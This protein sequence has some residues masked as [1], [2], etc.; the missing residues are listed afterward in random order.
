M[1]KRSVA[2]EERLVRAGEAAARRAGLSFSAW[3]SRA[4]EHALLVERGLRAVRDW[5]R[6]HGRLTPE[7]L[8]AADRLV[9]LWLEAPRTP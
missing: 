2:I 8:A 5:E 9:D 6:E 1:R 4:A 3:I 7:E